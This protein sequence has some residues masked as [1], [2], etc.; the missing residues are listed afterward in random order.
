MEADKLVACA[1]LQIA[2]LLYAPLRRVRVKMN[3]VS[4]SH[5][6]VAVH[7]VMDEVQKHQPPTA[8]LSSVL[9]PIIDTLNTSNYSEVLRDA[10][11]GLP[12]TSGVL[13]LA[14]ASIF[15]MRQLEVKQ[16]KHA[17]HPDFR[18]GLFSVLECLSSACPYCTKGAD[19]MTPKLVQVITESGRPDWCAL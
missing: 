18:T 3:V 19:L 5:V 2:D 14:C 6:Q 16:C 9:G 7:D 8:P 11:A 12:C 15:E 13:N 1:T 17:N 4:G 10:C